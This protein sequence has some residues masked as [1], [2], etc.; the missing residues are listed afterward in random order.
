MLRSI[1]TAIC[2]MLIVLFTLLL[3]GRS[4]SPV[5]A[6]EAAGSPQWQEI[7][8]KY[9]PPKVIQTTTSD[10]V[11]VLREQFANEL[12]YVGILSAL[13]ILSL[14]IVLSFIYKTTHTARDIVNASGLVV[15]IFATIFLVIL[16]RTDEQMTAAIGILGA[17][18]GYLFGTMQRREAKAEDNRPSLHR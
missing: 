10:Q 7:L 16:V 2:A 4:I 5:W 12:L 14:T 6:Q 3:H 8:K 17:V 11:I 18:T 9:D 1:G 13:Q 15:I